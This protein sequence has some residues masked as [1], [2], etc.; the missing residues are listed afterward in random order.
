MTLILVSNR[1]PVSLTRRG[2]H[3]E[4]TPSAG[5]VAVGLRSVHRR[6]GARWV[7]WPGEVPVEDREIV[8]G[9]LRSEFDCRP[10]F[11]PAGLGRQYYSGFANRTLW[12]L[13]HSLP[14]HA[15]YSRQEWQAYRRANRLFADKVLALARPGDTIWIHDYHLFLVPGLIRERLP[16]ATIG[17]FL[18]IPFPPYEV[19]R[20][21]PWNHELLQGILGADL[22]GFH[23]YD[24]VQSFL[25]AA[26]RSLGLDNDIGTMALG[27]RVVHVDA[28][29]MGIDFRRLS[30]ATASPKVEREVA[31]IHRLV[32]GKKLAF[33][34]SR[35]DYTKG[36]P[37]ELHAVQRFL[38]RYPRWRAKFSYLLAVTP[39]RERVPQY[40]QLKR[41]ID[42]LV[43]R[44]NSRFGDF[45]HT[46]IHYV[47]RPLSFEE[48]LALYRSS[49]V[50]LITPLRDGMNLVAKEYIAA[51][52]DEQG[53]LIL[54]E[55]AG[56]SK[57]LLEALIVNP[58]DTDAVADAIRAALSMPAAEQARRNQA[59]RGRLASA[60]VNAWADRFLSRLDEAIALSRRLAVR[61]LSSKARSDLVAAYGS[62][63]R[64]LL[65]LDYDG[66][67]VPFAAEP[68]DA[69]PPESLLAILKALA[70]SPR[71]EVALVSGR[72]RDDLERWFSG[73]GLTLAAEH[74]AWV[75]PSRK[76]G[77]RS[78]V[79]VD[80]TWKARVRPI[81]EGFVHRVPASSIEEKDHSLAWHYRA[82]DPE[83]GAAAARELTDTLTGLTANLDIHV[84]RG[85]K[86]VEAKTAQASKGAL[87]RSVYGSEMYDFI[88]A[89]GDDVTD[90][91]LFEALPPGAHTIRV[92]LVASR[93]RHNVPDHSEAVSILE[94][95]AKA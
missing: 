88:L 14:V 91:T 23:T 35:L 92:G 9:R 68:S 90:E 10:V 62:A 11:L 21:L 72:R 38:E 84:L 86:V 37:L 63:R 80:A 78:L 81:L 54:S 30:E 87:Y 71:T 83:S 64:R 60:D 46:P 58:N 73:F 6:Y 74:G 85:N 22:V 45:Q 4:I 53:V 12:P 77:W 17:F 44:I 56:A 69:A 13:L 5:G 61:L 15:T 25:G 39:S 95:L 7:G 2:S 51:R 8:E 36:I 32:R 41:E 82:A 3:L 66:T 70:G 31:R 79:S 26:R 24:Y 89:V 48:L 20:L 19:F 34:I 40:A 42:E 27:R 16:D 28:F 76:P 67:L 43:G 47:Y 1:L 59:M 75:R 29:P 50:A 18:H 55:M 93:A 65:L 57:E 94:D 52:N 33:S 49:D